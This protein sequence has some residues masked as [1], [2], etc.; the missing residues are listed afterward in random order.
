MSLDTGVKK[1]GLPA[2]D[3]WG[4]V[5]KKSLRL[6]VREDNESCIKIVENGYSPAMRHLHRTHRMHIGWLHEVLCGL[7]GKGGEH[8]FLEKCASELMKADPFTKSIVPSKWEHALAQFG[9]TRR[10]NQKCG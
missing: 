3:F 2:L 1:V 4:V 5:L 8:A 10:K 7:D 6:K 9:M